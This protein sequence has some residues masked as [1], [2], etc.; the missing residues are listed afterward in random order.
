MNYRNLL[1]ICALLAGESLFA[2]TTDAPVIITEN[3]DWKPIRQEKEMEKGGILDFSATLDAPAGKYG[4]VVVRNGHFEFRDR[5]GVPARF[6]GTNLVDTA[7]FLSH[8]WS[9]RLAGQIAQAGFNLIR[10]HHHDNGLSVRKDGCSTSLNQQN[11]EALNYLIFCLKQKG[12]YIITDCYVSRTFTPKEIESWGTDDFKQLVLFNSDALDNWKAFVRNWFT[13][14]NPYTGMA[15]K[16]DPVLIAVN[17]INEGCIGCGCNEKISRVWRGSFEAW[18][19]K[20]NLSKQPAKPNE[21]NAFYNAQISGFVLERYLATYEEMHRFLYEELGMKKP[22]SD[23][24]IHGEWLNAFMRD[25]HDFGD[26]HFYSDHPKYPVSAWQ[27][28]G[29]I[30]NVSSLV[31]PHEKLCQ[32]F[33]SRIWNKPFAITE[34]DYPKP[35]FFRAEGGVFPAAYGSLQN[36]DVMVQFACSHGDFNIMKSQTIGGPFDLYSDV[37]KQLSH[38]IGVKLFLG[39]EIK[40]SPVV[41][42]V[43]FRNSHNMSFSQLPSLDVK[44]LGLVAR[45]GTVILPNGKADRA[46]LP[47]GVCALLDTDINFPYDSYG[48]PVFKAKYNRGQLFRELIAGNILP[49][50]SVDAG[51]KIFRAPGNQLESDGINGTF[52]AEGDGINVLIL[53]AKRAGEADVLRVSNNVGRGV[54]SLQA[55]DGKPLKQS[56][57]MLFLHLT[58]TQASGLQFDNAEMRQFSSWGKRQHLAAHGEADVTIALAGDFELYSCDAAGKRLARVPLLREKDGAL[59]F[60]SNVFRKEG[61][62]FVYELIRI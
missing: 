14:P 25:R 41:I 42:A 54:F 44:R 30:N 5:P 22:V 43:A 40:P 36:W 38:R 59:H 15:L 57:R 48:V 60:Q 18:L 33:P 7:Q 21:D 58:D 47:P 45:L 52:R 8:E 23:R 26:N 20:N 34:F 28:P 37:V 13:A 62:V 53:P 16:D 19:K 1:F 9:E 12:I 11:L 61:C 17:L 49:K 2:G 32:M 4:P 29:L 10:I 35:N 27:L 31:E 6:Y 3:A 46:K 56:R 51:C 24:S 55:V 39:R 50:D